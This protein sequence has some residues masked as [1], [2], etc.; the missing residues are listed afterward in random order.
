MIS[1]LAWP[2]SWQT[3]FGL[4]V[5]KATYLSTHSLTWG[6]A[7]RRVGPLPYSG[8]DTNGQ[9][10]Y[11]GW[12]PRSSRLA[13]SQRDEHKQNRARRHP[14]ARPSQFSNEDPFTRCRPRLPLHRRVRH[15]PEPAAQ[16]PEQRLHP[17]F[18][19]SPSCPASRDRSRSSTGCTG[20]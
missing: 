13:F 3:E 11:P 7:R 14:P 9:S 2:S 10:V 5:S 4:Q 1:R 20:R 15:L 19:E 16:E 18:A 17:H 12:P 8:P 6:P